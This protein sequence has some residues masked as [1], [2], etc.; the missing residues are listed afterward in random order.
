MNTHLDGNRY[1][2]AEMHSAKTLKRGVKAALLVIAV[3]SV[4]V[5]LGVAARL[6]RPPLAQGE[7]QATGT[8]VASNTIGQDQAMPANKGN[9]VETDQRLVSIKNQDPQVGLEQ[10]RAA[11]EFTHLESRRVGGVSC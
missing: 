2:N 5:T 10:V 1:G 9:D 8:K 11:M 7:V 3:L 4:F 6:H